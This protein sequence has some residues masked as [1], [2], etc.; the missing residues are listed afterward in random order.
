MMKVFIVY[1]LI[2]CSAFTVN[3]QYEDYGFQRDTSINVY[4]SLTNKLGNA[5]GGGLN[6]CQFSEIDL[7][8]NG[9]KDLFIYD[10]SSAKI[11]TFINNGTSGTIDYTYAPEYREKFPEIHYWAQLHDYNNDGK[12]DVFTYS[13]GAGITVYKNTSDVINGL[14]FTKVAET[15][16]SLQDTQLLNIWVTQV[17]FPAISDID[18]DG[19]LDILNFWGLGEYVQMH[20]NMSMEHY[21]NADSLEFERVDFCWGDFAEGTSNNTIT[22]NITCPGKGTEN[23]KDTNAIEHTGSTMLALDLNGDTLKDLLIGDVD[24]PGLFALYNGGSLSD[25]VMT[26]KDTIFPSNT[27]RIDLISFPA[28][29]YV[30]V[31]NDGAKDLIASPFDANMSISE[32]QKSC[33]LYENSGI[34]SSPVF[35]YQYDN[36][37]QKDMIDLGAGAYPVLFDYDF[38]GLKDL[39]ISNFGKHDSSYYSGG[40]LYSIYISSINLFKNTGTASDPEFAFV[41]DDFAGIKSRKLNA[42]YPTF[43]DIDDDGAVEMIIGKSTGKLDLYENIA[44]A[45]QPLNMVLSQT[46]YYGIYIGNTVSQS[47]PSSTPQLFDLD[48]DSLLDLIIGEKA[49]TINFYKN[50]GTAQTP[51]FTLIT[52]SLGMVD[53][54]KHTVSNYGFTT[55]HFFSDSAGNTILF[56]GSESGYIYY[57]KDIDGNLGGTFTLADS[58]LLYIYE[59]TRGALTTGNLDD[60]NYPEMITGNYSGGVAYFDGVHP[61]PI[62]I[63]EYSVN[64]CSLDIFPNPATEVAY[65]KIPE[66]TSGNASIKIIDFKGSEISSTLIEPGRKVYSLNISTFS[67]GLY[68]IRIND[69]S[70]GNIFSGK[71]MIMH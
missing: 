60:D 7:D 57:Y 56:T 70:H 8:Q 46:D 1:F 39:F 23:S 45:G 34:T 66:M 48:K 21:G 59:G 11:I 40:F 36:F 31:N 38:D 22:L 24:Y 64:T 13:Y 42:I 10:R 20:Q 9:I 43:G 33:W 61:N 47:I 50:T 63:N 41:T 6:S 30:D 4:D 29:S 49:G 54:T 58:M 16:L 28:P 19:D 14:K 69:I 37:L 71:L 2:I 65:I 52:D 18:N 12:E 32:N 26:S 17:D 51:A 53:V 68:F 25:A 62:G 67:N 55:P 5:W 44:A 15:L 27:N 35:N 3:A